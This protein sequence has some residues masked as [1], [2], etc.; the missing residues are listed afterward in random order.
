[1]QLITTARVEAIKQS[2]QNII[3]LYALIVTL[4]VLIYAGIVYYGI[5]SPQAE[6]KPTMAQSTQDITS[7]Y[8]LDKALID[9][10]NYLC[11]VKK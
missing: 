2:T 5:L 4:G 6:A 1:M 3:N 8:N 10:D 7:H 11:F 9:D